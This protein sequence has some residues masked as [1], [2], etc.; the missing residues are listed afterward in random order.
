MNKKHKIKTSNKPNFFEEAIYLAVNAAQW[1]GDFKKEDFHLIKESE[2]FIKTQEE[3]DLE[4]ED[5][6]NFQVN[7][8][9]EAVPIFKGDTFWDEVTKVEEEDVFKSSYLHAWA[10][11]YEI[12][13]INEI[14]IE[15]FLYMNLEIFEDIYSNKG[16]LDGELSSLE[17]HCFRNSIW[18]N[19]IDIKLEDILWL[20][21]NTES[22]AD[23]K[24]EI[25]KIYIDCERVFKEFQ[26]KI[27][28][29]EYIVNKHYH[30]IEDRF[31]EVANNFELYKDT[32]KFL[33]MANVKSLKDHYSED[34]VIRFSGVS[35]NGGSFR[36][37]SKKDLDT[38]VIMGIMLFELYDYSLSFEGT[39]DKII[40]KCKA[41][42]DD[43]RFTILNLI[44]ER[45]YYVKELAEKMGLTSASI[46]H[47]LTILFQAGF[48]E[49][50]VKDR[51]TYYNIKDE[52][53]TE[54]GEQ[55][56]RIGKDISN[57]KG[58]V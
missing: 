44:S 20:I 38:K 7:I 5:V 50:T 49:P 35:Y 32:E 55:L 24:F 3:I 2:R 29:C 21:E 15:E 52:A 43:T 8:L 4:F 10:Q 37:S 47:H 23:K 56:I 1:E 39:K 9:S 6:Y 18:K 27:G 36:V 45:P 26:E 40:E 22:S 31:E 17:N 16:S 12:L 30:L 25:I 53:F 13:S 33:E 28:A 48:I 11:N 51:K 14:N 57:E 54:L 19:E 42:G 41:I 46:S 34:I 58:K